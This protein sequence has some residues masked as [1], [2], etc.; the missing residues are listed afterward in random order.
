MKKNAILFFISLIMGI[1]LLSNA[2]ES[3]EGIKPALLVIDVQNA[4][5]GLMD[6]DDI[7]G[8]VEYINAYIKAFNQ[9]GYPVIY[10]YHVDSNFGTAHGSEGYQ[11]IDQIPVS[12]DAKIVDKTYGNSFNKTELDKIL[13]ESGCNTLFLCGLSA[14]GCVFA[15][16]VGGLDRDYDTN[17]LKKAVMSHDK[18]ATKMVEDVTNA[19]GP[20]AMK[21]ILE[22]I[23]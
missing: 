20:K 1:S 13:K 7:D 5:M 9:L 14:S 19:I 21:M 2:Q 17:I 16:W 15:T 22:N 12:D 8:P 6:Q 10:V 3:E 23:N 18:E 4:Y 11:F